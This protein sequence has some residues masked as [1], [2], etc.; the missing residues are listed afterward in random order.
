MTS[1]FQI[2]EGEFKN[3]WCLQIVEGQKITVTM[4]NTIEEAINALDEWRY[5]DD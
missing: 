1:I 4:Y 5:E 3:M 2:V